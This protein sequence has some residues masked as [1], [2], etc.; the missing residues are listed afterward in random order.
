MMSGMMEKVV[1]FF[2]NSHTDVQVC[3]TV[4][5]VGRSL[6]RGDRG[7]ELGVFRLSFPSRYGS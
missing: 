6:A 7:L 2:N 1:D 5:D 3:W 4:A